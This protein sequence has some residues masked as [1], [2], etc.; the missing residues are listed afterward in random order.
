MQRNVRRCN[1]DIKLQCYKTYVRPIIEYAS[2]A[3]D[4]NNKNVI[5]KVESVQRKAARF[6][7][8]DYNKDSSVSKMI[9]K[10]NLD[11]IELR[12]KIKKLKLM[13]SI[14]WQKTFL[15]NAIKPTY[16]RDK[17][18]F[19]PI[20]ARVQ[21]YA[22]SFIPSVIDQWNKLP[23]AMQNVDD[24]KAFENSMFEFYRDF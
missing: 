9:K 22:V 10:L 1:R 24:T 7:L 18:K 13:H 15:S 17:I 20:N 19:K 6:I 8:N 23:V 4:T 14:A 2:P 11:S 5:Q 16:G 12:P 3:W 21:S